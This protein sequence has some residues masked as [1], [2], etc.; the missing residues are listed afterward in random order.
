VILYSEGFTAAQELGH[1]VVALFT[2]ASQLLSNCQHYDWGLRSM[3]TVLNTGGSIIQGLKRSG[4]T[5]TPESEKQLLIKA[6]RVNTLSKLTFE[7][8]QRF[9]KLLGDIFPGVPSED[10]AHAELE[11]AI[12]E[13]MTN[14][15]FSLEFDPG[16]VRKMLQLKEALDQRIGCLVV[17]PSGCGKSTLWRVLQAALVKCGQSI[18]THVMNPKSMPRSRL[19]GEMDHDTREWTDGVLTAAARQVVKEPPSMRSWIVCDGDVDPEW[20]ES[21][22]SVRTAAFRAWCATVMAHSAP[23]RP[24]PPAH[25]PCLIPQVLDDNHLLT[26]PNGERI[27]FG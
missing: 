8:G 14:K 21:L 15:P 9:V 11:A 20:I 1:K 26:L 25:M 10:I 22:N 5:V 6:I 4:V 23:P 16:Q 19:L 24:L 13:V 18:V 17:G 12:K 27:A 3:K 7:D 2:L